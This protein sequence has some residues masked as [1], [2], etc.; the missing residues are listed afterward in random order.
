MNLIFDLGGVVV[1]WNPQAICA[2]AFDV[3]AL[4]QAA[5]THILQHPDWLALDRGS[6]A[7]EDA[8]QRAA[9]RTAWSPAAVADFFDT[10]LASLR[11]KGDTVALMQRMRAAGHSLYCLSNMPHHALTYLEQAYTFWDLFSARVISCQVGM[12]KPEPGIYA[13]L[14]QHCAI[15]AAHSVFIDDM[16]VNVDAAAAF[17]IHPLRFDNAAQC[18]SALNAWLNPVASLPHA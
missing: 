9:T 5:M 4:R 18:E 13:H 12:C 6:L 10:V 17:G 11:L 14:L 8:I 16:Q 3:P 7:R 1:E 2:Q 15:E